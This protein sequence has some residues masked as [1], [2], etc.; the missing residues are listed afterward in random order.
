[1]NK[2]LIKGC[3]SQFTFEVANEC[4]LKENKTILM[5]KIKTKDKH[6]KLIV[7]TYFEKE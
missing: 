7:R 3:D 1:M 4:K 2:G 5:K 6:S